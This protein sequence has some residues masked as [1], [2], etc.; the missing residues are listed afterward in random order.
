MGD[1]A[2]QVPVEFGII[3]LLAHKGQP[4]RG[5]E[6]RGGQFNLEIHEFGGYISGFT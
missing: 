2:G 5:G 3:Q 4:G 6:R 1:Q